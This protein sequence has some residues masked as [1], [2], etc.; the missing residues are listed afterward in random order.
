MSPLW[1][2]KGLA[3]RLASD[4]TLE[5][6]WKVTDTPQL[7]GWTGT[8]GCRYSVSEHGVLLSHRGQLRDEGCR[9]QPLPLRYF[10]EVDIKMLL[11]GCGRMGKRL[12]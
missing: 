1:D 10:L 9:E 6:V 3:W 7:T 8:H 5:Q 12:G 2:S 11:K 4:E